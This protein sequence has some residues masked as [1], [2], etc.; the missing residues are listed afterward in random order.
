MIRRLLLLGALLLAVSLATY[1]AV[2]PATT[3]L[4]A[5]AYTVSE[6]PTRPS[7]VAALDGY[8]GYLGDAVRGDF[9]ETLR[10]EPVATLLGRTFFKSLGLLAVATGLATILGVAV[11]LVGHARRGSLAAGLPLA[12]SVGLLAMPSFL[13]GGICQVVNVEIAVRL[14]LPALPTI[15]A[16]WDAHLIMP[17][18]VLAA[19]PTA[20]VAR[21]TTRLLAEVDGEHFIRTARAKGLVASAVLVRHTLRVAAPGVLAAVALGLRL[22]VGT[23]PVVEI[24]FMYPGMGLS[25]LSSLRAGDVAATTGLALAI[26]LMLWAL[27]LVFDAAR[28]MLDPRLASGTA[29]GAT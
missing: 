18:L 25:F 15:G 13:I 17:A 11:A 22:A 28:R 8:A 27:A 12:L 16:G 29:G 14:G 4:T 1:V 26:A 20:Y 2:V 6:I 9:G 24:V 10:G 23:L 7:L 21:V 19:R 3:P 5:R